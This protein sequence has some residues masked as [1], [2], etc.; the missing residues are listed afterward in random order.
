MGYLLQDQKCDL[1]PSPDVEP[2]LNQEKLPQKFLRGWMMVMIM[3][4]L[5]SILNCDFSFFLPEVKK[6]P[7]TQAQAFQNDNTPHADRC[8]CTSSK[9][10]LAEK[11][12]VYD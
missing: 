10:N 6:N 5:T 1:E 4:M 9:V 3:L 12:T 7:S 2:V 8:F 11:L